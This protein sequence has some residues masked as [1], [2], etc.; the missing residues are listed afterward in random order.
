M[1]VTLVLSAGDV[2]HICG[3]EEK[4][5][6]TTFI[7]NS[8]VKN[9]AGGM[10]H[11]KVIGGGYISFTFTETYKDDY[12][13]CFPPFEDDPPITTIGNAK[14]HYVLWLNDCVRLYAPT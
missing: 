10:L 5:L 1:V 4:Y 8:I 11:N 12:P 9:L 6:K 7:K 2:V 13:L 3:Y 14:D